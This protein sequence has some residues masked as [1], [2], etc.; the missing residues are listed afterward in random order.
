MPQYNIPEIVANYEIDF[1]LPEYRLLIEFHGRQHYEYIPFFHDG[2]Y[3]FED[4]KTR[5]EMVRDA[6]IRWKYNYIE[7]NYKHFNLLKE[8]F[9]E[10]VITTILSQKFFK[11][12]KK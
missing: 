7:F 9:G 1:Y 11:R 3:T 6:A 2:D 4:Q 12:N 5:D 8:Q 10:F